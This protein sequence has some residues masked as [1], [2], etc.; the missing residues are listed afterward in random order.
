MRS[1][2]GIAL[3]GALLFALGCGGK[4]KPPATSDDTGANEPDPMEAAFSAAAAEPVADAGAPSAAE[5]ASGESSDAPAAGSEQSARTFLQQFLAKGADHAALSKSLRPT[6]ADY[7]AM[8]DTTTAAKIEAAHAKEWD[9]GK[10]VI[11]PKDGKQTEVRVFGATG[12]ELASGGGNASEFPGGYKKIGAHLAPTVT[13]FAFKF[14]QPGKM[15]GM[16]YD[17]LAFVNGHW[18]IAPK[19]WHGLGE[20]GGGGTPISG[21]GKGHRKPHAKKNK[22]KK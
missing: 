6:S 16:T 5:E 1:T 20:D 15:S 2:R 19:P 14:V 10:V 21:G 9:A 13:F 11:R 17:G 8:F 18:V 4:Q 22:K 12:A 3:A 7:K